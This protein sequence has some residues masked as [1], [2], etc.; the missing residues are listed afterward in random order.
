MFQSQI[1]FGR[2]KIF[3]FFTGQNESKNSASSEKEEK[4]SL[5]DWNAAMKD[6]VDGFPA[7]SDL[8]P[9]LVKD[10]LQKHFEESK[11]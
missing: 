3:E 9:K 1:N 5:L 11:V 6:I 7:S 8:N 4:E 10:L 2:L